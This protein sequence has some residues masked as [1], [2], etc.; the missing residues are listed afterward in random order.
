MGR[1][2]I[3]GDDFNVEIRT[4]YVED[5]LSLNAI[6][7][8]LAERTGMSWHPQ[9]VKRKL[10]DMGVAEIRGKRTAMKLFHEKR[11]AQTVGESS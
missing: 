4:L 6:A 3:Y 11:K 7:R 5:G 9:T 1:K 8:L 2:Q 10:T